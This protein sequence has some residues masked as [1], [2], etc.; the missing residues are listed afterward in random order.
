MQLHLLDHSD[1]KWKQVIERQ[2]FPASRCLKKELAATRYRCSGFNDSVS[3]AHALI[4]TTCWVGPLCFDPP[5]VFSIA[6]A[7]SLALL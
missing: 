5:S 6:L 7:L 1:T 4:E 2:F 3:R